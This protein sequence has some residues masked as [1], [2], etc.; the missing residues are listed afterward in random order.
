M[1]ENGVLVYLRTGE[2]PE[3][4]DRNQ[5]PLAAVLREIAPT[6]EVVS[7]SDKLTVLADEVHKTGPFPASSRSTRNS[8]RFCLRW[9]VDIRHQYEPP[10][11]V[12]DLVG[13]HGNGVADS[14]PLGSGS[15][16]VLPGRL[17]R[18]DPLQPLRA[19]LSSSENFR[20]S[21]SQSPDR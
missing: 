16:D 9:L 3:R 12:A 15:F 18:A 11:K 13:Y 6:V 5:E 21:N 10:P 20:P 19:E 2:V 4:T 1:Q 7:R 14:L 8:T 17:P